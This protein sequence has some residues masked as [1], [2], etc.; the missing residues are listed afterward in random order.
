MSFVKLLED[1][2]GVISMK[3][4]LRCVLEWCGILYIGFLF[5]V[6]IWHDVQ[7]GSG[8]TLNSISCQTFVVY[9]A[10]NGL[11]YLCPNLWCNISGE[12]FFLWVNFCNF[13]F[14]SEFTKNACFLCALCGRVTAFCLISLKKTVKNIFAK[15]LGTS[16][17]H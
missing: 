11:V 17:I 16:Q 4:Q 3:T 15:N 7:K 6:E 10:N 12:I 1:I 13:D 14:Y 5:I 2:V 9:P 8:Y